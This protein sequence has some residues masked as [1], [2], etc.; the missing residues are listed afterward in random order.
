[1][2]SLGFINMDQVGSKSKNL[3]NRQ[4]KSGRKFKAK[5]EKMIFLFFKC[6]VEQ[7]VESALIALAAI[8][9]GS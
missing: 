3:L 4:T 7:S 2:L 6:R 8:F 9:F 5:F 1:M